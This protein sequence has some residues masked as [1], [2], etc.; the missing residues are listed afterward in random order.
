MAARIR[1][2]DQV[3][4]IAGKDK[5]RE[6]GGARGTVTAVDGVRDRVTVQG[7]NLVTRHQKPVQG[8]SR[9]G[10]IQKEAPIHISNVMLLHKGEPT[11]V[12]F[13]VVNGKKVR[14]SKRHDEAIDA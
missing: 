12:G 2:G 13:R 5:H 11:R 4:V 3:I 7:V 8:Q 9:G 10:I 6:K 14:W 1:K